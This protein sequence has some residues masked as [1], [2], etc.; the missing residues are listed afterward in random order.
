LLTKYH[1]DPLEVVGYEGLFG[2]CGYLVLLPIITF[3]P[4]SF[5]AEACVFT[6]QGFPFLERP[7]AYFSE[8]FSNGGLLFF[9]ILGIF[10]IATFNITGVTVT[11]YINALARS[12]GDV[13]RTIL[14]WG[15]GIIITVTA[16][17]TYPN[18]KWELLNGG[19]IALELLGFVILVSGNLVYNQIIK[20][21]GIT[22]RNTREND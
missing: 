17:A 12:I 7:F 19:A 14:V 1:L 11:K 16:G 18:Y 4:C 20:I 10:S 3:I 6:E 8:A 2:L 15:I 13:T 9:C 21:P 5:G 22:E